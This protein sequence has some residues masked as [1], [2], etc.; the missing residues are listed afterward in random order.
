MTEKTFAA[1]VPACRREAFVFPRKEAS[2]LPACLISTVDGSET[3]EEDSRLSS[4][5]EAYLVMKR[6]TFV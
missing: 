2:G 5:Q 3:L 4:W 1:Q 6:F